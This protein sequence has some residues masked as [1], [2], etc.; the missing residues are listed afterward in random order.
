M[1]TLPPN[2]IPQTITLDSLPSLTIGGITEASI[3]LYNPT[4]RLSGDK[5]PVQLTLQF[6]SLPYYGY[7]D[8]HSMGQLTPSVGL[9]CGV[10]VAGW[11]DIWQFFDKVQS[12]VVPFTIPLDHAMWQRLGTGLYEVILPAAPLRWRVVGIKEFSD[13]RDVR[14]FDLTIV[15]RDVSGKTLLPLNSIPRASG[16]VL[17]PMLAGSGELPNPNNPLPVDPALGE[18]A[19]AAYIPR[20]AQDELVVSIIPEVPFAVSES[21]T[22]YGISEVTPVITAVISQPEYIDIY[23]TSAGYQYFYGQA[24]WFDVAN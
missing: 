17:N 14:S 11:D 6:R 4:V 10:D 3:A 22:E 2:F 20:Q 21:P 5:L 24:Q 8:I 12:G 19:T 7:Q 1:I 16:D 15:S 18:V 9:T 23:V 13:L